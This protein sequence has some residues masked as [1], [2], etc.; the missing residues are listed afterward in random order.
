MTPPGGPAG[1]A[2]TVWFGGDYNP[3]QWPEEVWADEPLEARVRRR[4]VRV[5]PRDAVVVPA[6][7]DD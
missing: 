5:G 6:D 1:R 2:R 3:E 4:P 7:G